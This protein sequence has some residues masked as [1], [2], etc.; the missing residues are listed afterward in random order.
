MITLEIKL[1]Y[2]SKTFT[3]KW[4]F[5][6]TLYVQL[7]SLPKAWRFYTNTVVMFVTFFKFDANLLSHVA[8]QMN[9]LEPP[10]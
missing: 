1:P 7:K 2:I 5:N 4:V 3:P 8:G 6:K 9:V 10:D